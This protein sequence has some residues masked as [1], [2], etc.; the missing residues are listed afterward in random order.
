[1][2]LIKTNITKIQVVNPKISITLP[3]RDAANP[4]NINAA[5]TNAIVN[6][7]KFFI[8]LFLVSPNGCAHEYPPPLGFCAWA[9]GGGFA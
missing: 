2:K 5:T 1:M 3:F 6:L 7:V 4:A 8:F 9:F